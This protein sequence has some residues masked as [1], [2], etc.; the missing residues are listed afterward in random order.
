MLST[1]ARS[2]PACKRRTRASQA[3]LEQPLVVDGQMRV[4]GVELAF[5]AKHAGFHEHLH[6]VGN[7]RLAFGAEVVVVPKRGDRA[8]LRLRFVGDVK[9]V[10]VALFKQVEFVEHKLERV[11]RENGRVAVFGRLV[12][13]Q[14]RFRFD[15]NRHLVQDLLQHQRP[16]HDLRLVLILL[17]R[18][19]CQHGALGVDIRFLVEHRF[20]KGVHPFGQRAKVFGW[21]HCLFLVSSLCLHCI[22]LL[23]KCQ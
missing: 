21:F 17:I 2:S 15:I 23:K 11:F 4:A 16:H 14:Q 1:R 22:S 3:F 5:H 6:S 9:N 13:G 19:G 20:A 8:K 10:P 18:L 12:A 7:E